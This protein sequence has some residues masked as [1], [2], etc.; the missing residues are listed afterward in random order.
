MPPSRPKLVARPHLVQVLHAAVTDARL[1]LVS[2][3]AG[4][5][6]TTLVQ[7]W[8]AS[9]LGRALS[10]AW[11]SLDS[12]DNDPVR[13][14]TGVIAALRQ[15]RGDLG[16]GTL[17][18]LRQLGSP[19]GDVLLP[20]LI[21][22]LND[23]DQ[24]LVLALDECEV[25][26][27]SAIH[28]DLSRL[29]EQLPVRLHLLMMTR[30]DPPLPVARFRARGWLAEIRMA[31]LRF[32][33]EE[34]ATFVADI[35]GIPDLSQ[36]E[37]K[38]LATRTEGWAAGVQLAALSLRNRSD[39][40]S[41]LATLSTATPRFIV[42]YLVEDVLNRQ[43]ED[44]RTFLQHTSILDRLCG[45]LCDAVTERSG[46]EAMLEQLEHAN[47]FVIPLD[48]ER[49]WYRYHGLFAEALRLR[50]RQTN[51]EVV[52]RLHSRAAAWFSA[53]RMQ[54]EAI[55]HTLA[56]GNSSSAAEQIADLQQQLFSEG[57]HVT[58]QRWL[59]EL[60]ES[61]LG[62]H[63]PLL[64]ALAW[65]HF[66]LGQWRT[67]ADAVSRAERAAA[68][69]D[70]QVS[71]GILACLRAWWSLLR[72][73]G[74]EVIA[75]ATRGLTLLPPDEPYWRQ[76]AQL[77]LGWGHLLE[78]NLL[79]ALQVL[80]A[81]GQSDGNRLT[82]EPS[83]V[84][85]IFVLAEVSRL[86]G[87]LHHALDLC[88]ELLRLAGDPKLDQSPGTPLTTMR[89]GWV[90][91]PA[92]IDAL[93]LQAEV[94]REL[95]QLS[96]ADDLLHEALVLEAPYGHLATTTKGPSFLVRGRL[97]ASQNKATEAL[98]ALSRA[99]V[100]AESINSEPLRELVEA[101]AMRVRLRVGDVPVV[102]D[103]SER[104]GRSDAE[105]LLYRREAEALTLVRLWLAR[106]ETRRAATLLEQLQAAAE[107]GGRSGSLAEILSLQAR[108]AWESGA[109][110]RALSLLARALALAEPG[111]Y[112]RLFADEGALL[113]PLLAEFAAAQRSG[114]LIPPSPEYVRTV[115]VA[116]GGESGWDAAHTPGDSAPGA[117]Q[118][119]SARELEVL[120]LMA[121]GA[122]NERIAADL[123]IGVTT[124][125]TH[126]NAI[127]RK[128]GASNRFEA[129]ARAR[130]V[131]LLK[132]VGPP[133]Q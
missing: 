67:L 127:F 76:S 51:P 23:L 98:E 7:A 118:P 1:T 124:V 70:D 126:V 57:E 131:G 37:I 79:Q 102:V 6:K 11:L 133:T 26:D 129:V 28:D 94:M 87:E 130:A 105:L 114:H 71:S 101:F 132:T 41:L 29:V 72:A 88:N 83:S 50:Q 97:L 22:A 69:H 5:G 106:A 53:T 111:G 122:P 110:D 81:A 42:D 112:V 49:L 95:N 109:R 86:R 12:A 13:F 90:T 56:A 108:L 48:A 19:N 63:P 78:G 64:V 30:A 38:L 9:D 82:G 89:G 96:A 8:H 58:L 107:A 15:P 103:W 115:L 31:D 60:S 44:V 39:G 52:P 2:A 46:G 75:A 84:G 65:T 34:V 91:V 93:V 104:V 45:P 55:E 25:I 17:A 66:Q 74:G 40:T 128:L 3:P 14:W 4:F 43:S 36:D 68:A 123:V 117:Y 77:A 61:V 121:T 116:A 113:V 35:I 62:E 92:R 54:R 125:K 99:A 21:R 32:R 120:R 33:E 24:D 20:G 119:L 18:R 59:G 10:L 80:V 16:T 47:L 73:D 27:S 85:S 100:D